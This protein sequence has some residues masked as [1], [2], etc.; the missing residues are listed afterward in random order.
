MNGV[1][2]PTFNAAAV[3][4]GVL[5]DDAEHYRCLEEAAVCATACQMRALSVDILINVDVQD[6]LQLWEAHK[7]HMVDD[8]LCDAQ[9]VTI[10]L[11]LPV[12]AYVLGHYLAFQC[13]LTLFLI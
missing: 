4:L 6:P 3:A 11:A 2:S 8:F 1:P 9:Q 5:E 13:T 12:L 7:L 10:W